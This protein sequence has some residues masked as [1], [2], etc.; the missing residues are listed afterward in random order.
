[1]PD[2]NGTNGN[3]IITESSG[4]S[5]GT[6]GAGDDTITGLGGDDVIAGGDGSDLLIGDAR[7]RPPR[8]VGQPV[9]RLGC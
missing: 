3:D 9:A 8:L 7:L 1:M 4:F 6:P 5:G 2:I